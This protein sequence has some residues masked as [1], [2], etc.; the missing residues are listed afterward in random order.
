[1]GQSV[2]HAIIGAVIFLRVTGS[3]VTP[4]HSLVHVDQAV[5]FL[6]IILFIVGHLAMILW[7]YLV[8]LKLRKNMKKMGAKYERSLSIKKPNKSDDTTSKNQKR[9]SFSRIPIEK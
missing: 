5:F 2:W 7:L 3:P 9:S 8:P 6:T 4:D 1:V